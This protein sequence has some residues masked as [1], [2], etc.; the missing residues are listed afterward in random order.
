MTRIKAVRDGTL[1][2]WIAEREMIRSTVPLHFGQTFR[3]GPRSFSMR[4]VR[5]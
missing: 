2:G 3:C 1:V 4:S 5:V